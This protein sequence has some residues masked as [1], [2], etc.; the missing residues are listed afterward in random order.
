[1]ADADPVAELEQALA[2][3]L[4]DLKVATE[5]R[6]K[7]NATSPGVLEAIRHEREVMERI[8]ELVERIDEL[9]D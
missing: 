2:R 3:A 8:Q 5:E 1:V 9:H 4:S 6:R 7:L